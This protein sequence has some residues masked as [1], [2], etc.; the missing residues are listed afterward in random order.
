MSK[1]ITFRVE[2]TFSGEV[3]S[4]EQIKEIRDNVLQALVHQVDTGMGIAPED[5]DLI[6]DH[7]RVT[8]QY[9]NETAIHSF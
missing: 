6:T 4:D 8:P 9:L 1:N 7:I 5:A 2:L 3:V